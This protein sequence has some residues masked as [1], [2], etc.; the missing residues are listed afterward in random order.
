MTTKIVVKQRCQSG[1]FL[2]V[3][4]KEVASPFCHLK[5]H[6]LTTSCSC[7]CMSKGPLPKEPKSKSQMFF[8]G[9][10]VRRAIFR[11]AVAGHPERHGGVRGQV[12]QNAQ[13]RRIHEERLHGELRSLLLLKSGCRWEADTTLKSS[14]CL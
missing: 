9:D 8:S 6:I 3:D 2:T 12:R 10:S 7:R 4:I 11:P 13:R 1:K 5:H 14:V